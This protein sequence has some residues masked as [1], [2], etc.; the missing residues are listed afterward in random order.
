M[1]KKHGLWSS[2][3]IKCYEKQ[4]LQEIDTLKDP[5]LSSIAKILLLPDELSSAVTRNDMCEN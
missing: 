2:L 3:S 5:V 4:Y 1:S